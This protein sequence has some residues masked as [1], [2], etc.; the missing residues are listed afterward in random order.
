[1]ADHFELVEQ[2]FSGPLASFETLLWE[3]WQCIDCLEIV[4]WDYLLTPHPL[5]LAHLQICPYNSENQGNTTCMHTTIMSQCCEYRDRIC[6]WVAC[7][8]EL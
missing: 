7:Y 2:V 8:F 1:M 6:S 3:E 5:F 4:K